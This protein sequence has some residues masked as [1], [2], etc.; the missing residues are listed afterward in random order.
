MVELTNTTYSGTGGTITGLFLNNPGGIIS[1]VTISDSGCVLLGSPAFRN[2]I[3][4]SPAGYYDLG[5]SLGDRGDDAGDRPAGIASGQ[6]KSFHFTLSGVGLDGLNEY[7]FV[8]ETPEGGDHFLAVRFDGFPGGES[9]TVPANQVSAPETVVTPTAGSSVPQH[10]ALLPNYPNPFNA[11]TNIGFQLP[12]SG[13]VALTIYDVLGRTARHLV[14][15]RQAAGSYIARWNG[16]DDQG[17]VLKSGVYFCVFE[18]GSYRQT[19]KM[20]LS[21]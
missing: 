21:R 6:T 10:Y 3:D 20:V 2:G 19:I 4:A 16:R 5:A 12:A 7:S 9:E 15:A 14:D 11:T 8:E 13:H 1:T 18:S 17:C